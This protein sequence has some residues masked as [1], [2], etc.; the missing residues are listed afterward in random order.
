MAK[1]LRFDPPLRHPAAKL[2][3]LLLLGCVVGSTAA[4]GQQAVGEMELLRGQVK[5]RHLGQ[6]RIFRNVGDRAPLFVGDVVHTGGESRARLSFDGKNETVAMYGKSH[7]V[8]NEVTPSRSRFLLNVGKALFGVF[9]SKNFSVQTST[10]TIGVKGTEFVVGTDG[11]QTFLLTITGVVGMVSAAF[12]EL[13]VVAELNQASFARA[14]QPATP[15]V[16]VP[17][18]VR[19]RI[20]QEEGLEPFE[21]IEFPAAEA[22]ENAAE[23][24][25]EIQG[26]IEEGTRSARPTGEG[27]GSIR[28]N[29]NQEG[30]VQ[31]DV[32]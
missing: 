2:L 29:F 10:A 14:N 8:V 1:R 18:E 26:L 32:Q 17:P 6:G 21:Q 22:E 11:Q 19:E 15:P 24:V 28:F 13:E 23:T 9:R 25:S 31:F 3:L 7:F 30:S 16:F 27:S 20:I 5:V 12:R 4:L